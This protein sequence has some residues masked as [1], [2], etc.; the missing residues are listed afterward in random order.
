MKNI[1]FLHVLITIAG[2]N[3]IV[4]IGGVIWSLI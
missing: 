4:R 3:L 1:R 2:I